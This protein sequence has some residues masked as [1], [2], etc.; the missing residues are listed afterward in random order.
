MAVFGSNS[1]ASIQPDPEQQQAIEHVHGPLL[2]L[3][4]AGTGK[5][6][7]L[8]RRIAHLIREGR[9]RPDEVLALTYTDN[10]A[11]EMLQRVGRE[12]GDADTKG[13]QVSTFHAYCNNLLTRSERSFRVVDDK[14]LWIFLRRNLRELQLN[15]YIRAANIGKFLEDL[16][17]FIRRCH[18][19]LV[20]P[21]Q[22]REY[23][24]RIEAGE[25]PLP[26]VAKSKQ[27][28]EISEEEA[29]GRCREIA[30]VFET[31]ERMLR[32]R[33]L[34]TFGH[35]ILGANRLLSENTELLQR[36]R[37][38]ARFILIDEFQ[39]ANFAQIEV[40]KKLAGD[41]QSIF[42]VGDPDQGIYRFRGASSG[43]FEL[44]Q[45]AF[46]ETKLVLL[47]KNR[48]ST[49][50][51]LRCAHALIAENPQFALN[52]GGAEYHR[53]PLVSARDE[54]DDVKAG[55]RAPVEAVLVTGSFME[56]TDLVSTL[57]DRRRRSRCNWR[58][59]G[60]L[61]RIHTHRD[62]AA[63][64]LARN[65]I[66]FSIE[67]LDVLDAPEVRDLLA[68]V[69][70]VVSEADSA[71]LMRVAALCQFPIDPDDLKH[72][73][74]TLPRDPTATIASILPDVIGGPELLKKIRQ[75][76]EETAG[77]KIYAT[78]L[79]LV[80]IFEIPRT[81][82]IEAM[83]QFVNQ[84][85]K[86][87]IIDDGSPAEFLDYLAYYREARGTIPL[88]T[89]EGEDA[90]RLMTAHSAKGLEFDHVFILRAV[91]GSFPA[92]YREPLIEIPVELRN[93]GLADQ[94]EKRISEQEERRLFYVAMTRA[95]DSLSMYGQFGRGEKDK[96][97]PGFL[98]EL[99]KHRELKGCF[100]HRTCRE[101]QTEIFAAA[102]SPSL[103]RLGEWIAQ[104]P[105][106]DLTSTLSASSI[107]HYE[108]C[109]L[110][111]KLEREWR[112]PGEPSAALQFGASMHRVLLAYY[113]SVRWKRPLSEAELIEL[114]KNDLAAEGFADQYQREL[115]EQKGILELREF[116]AGAK[117]SQAEVMHTEERFSIKIGATDLVGRI[118]RIDRG[119]DGKVI[120][121]DYKTGR[122]RSQED[123]D[124]SL[125]LT[126]YALAARETWG[127][128]VERLGFHNLESNTTVIT[129][130]TDTQLE[131]AK[132][133]VEEVVSKIAAERFE[134]K[135]GFHCGFCAYR[136]LCPK[137]EKR[138]PQISLG[139]A[140]QN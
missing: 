7:V 52:S 133:K 117:R 81:P 30:S 15:Y 11:K 2:V 76:R 114:L 34:G 92:N 136:V 53:S 99:I 4:G 1:K 63:A 25:L 19:E 67:G 5:T 115:Y 9:A 38:R 62:E 10:A 127:Y 28:H 66:P 49:T 135:P 74:K 55:Q 72:K 14:Q 95:R 32:E 70:A 39:D 113:D 96:T 106:S 41:D 121:T 97:P 13:L 73:I 139:A 90:V 65:G 119:P 45:R 130:R 110:Q 33:N 6:T 12:I 140:G 57:L 124:E 58:G 29:I 46:P 50:P 20:G 122:P 123:A 56:A 104:S 87:P 71:S 36:E 18:D 54:E 31:V 75:A 83:L 108:T 23:V 21:E 125:Q 43:A 103:S 132:L 64:E 112:I 107:Q 3:A 27:A 40:L 102:E 116:I 16:L 98:R 79:A 94:D 93:S 47:R 138:V 80:G 120:I 129:F 126:L 77:R 134:P 44:F 101:F 60:I 42:A 48:R 26:R 78:L 37:A 118:D 89:F 69:G 61:Y 17:E 100:R 85:E 24:R 35:M 51:I 68:C 128:E 82:A 91:K 111:F 86:S 105:S 137:T 22:Y 8:T 59:I 109:P 131:Q 88:N 84:W